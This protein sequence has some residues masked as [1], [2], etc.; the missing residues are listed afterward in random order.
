MGV[1]NHRDNNCAERWR[2]SL[3]PYVTAII[4]VLFVV[5]PNHGLAGS[6]LQ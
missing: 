4:F 1:K 5:I 3:Y 2:K 6:A